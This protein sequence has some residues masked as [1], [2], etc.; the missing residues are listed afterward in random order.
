MIEKLKKLDVGLVKENIDVKNLTTFKVSSIAKALVIPNDLDSLITLLK[1]LKSEKIKYKVIGQGSNLIFV[2]KTFNGVLIRLDKFN[3]LEI[4]DNN[5]IIGAGYSL[6]ACALKLSKLG[7]KGMEFASGIPGSVG[8]SIVNN[9]GAYNSSMSHIIKSAK[10]LTKDYEVKIFTKEELGFKYRSSFLQY[11]DD[12]ICL[13]GEFILDKGISE[14]IL[15]TIEERKEKRFNSQP[16]NYPSAGS[17]FRN[18][19]NVSAWELIEKLGFKGK[20]IGGAQ[21]SNKHANFIINTNNATGK[22]IKKLILAIKK[23]VKKEYDID[24]VIEQEFVE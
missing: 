16:L 20:N 12:Y 7:F 15:K 5:I 14:N 1:F 18:P 23:E 19:P 6:M 22:D 2:N 8:G 11:K 13:E 10:V 9:A 4:K 24:L 17:V 21:V 3:K